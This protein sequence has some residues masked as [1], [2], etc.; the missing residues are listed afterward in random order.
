[1]LHQVAEV[2]G[3]ASYYSNKGND[4]EYLGDGGSTNRNLIGWNNK[5]LQTYRQ[6]GGGR[7]WR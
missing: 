3:G 4:W 2:D 7:W 6:S 5:R 1:M